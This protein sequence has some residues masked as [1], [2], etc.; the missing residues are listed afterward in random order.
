MPIYEFK[1]NKCGN[2]FEQ[3]VFSSDKEEELTCPSCGE[4]DTCRLMSL[5]SSGSSNSGKSLSSGLSSSCSSSSG[6]FSWAGWPLQPW[7]A[8]GIPIIQMWWIIFDIKYRWR[9][10]SRWVYG[11]LFWFLES[12]YCSKHISYL[13]WG[14]RP[15]SKKVAS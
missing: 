9:E 15:D 13:N 12:G 7:A 5:F 6:G 10:G 14:F 2:I 4:R 1:C 11:G 8:I 3:L